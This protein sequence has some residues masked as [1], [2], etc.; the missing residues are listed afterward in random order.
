VVSQHDAVSGWELRA[1]D[2]SLAFLLTVDGVRHEVSWSPSFEIAE[3]W[4]HLAGTFDGDRLELRINGVAVPGVGQNVSGVITPSAGPLRIGQSAY[5]PGRIFT[6]QLAEVRVWE[7]A[8]NFGELNAGLFRRLAGDEAGLLAYWPLAEGTGDSLADQSMG[9]RHGTGESMGWVAADL[10]PR[11]PAGEVVE[12][13]LA[14]R[15]RQLAARIKEKKAELKRAVGRRR[16]REDRKELRQEQLAGGEA[17]WEHER[18]RLDDTFDNQIRARE[19]Q[20]EAI[21]AAQ[22]TEDLN[23]VDALLGDIVEKTH[24]Q[25]ERA[26]DTLDRGDSP[27]RLGR[28]CLDLRYVAGGGGGGATLP[29][30]ETIVEGER[31]T[32]LHLDFA[33]DS[34]PQPPVLAPVNKVP[35]VVGYTSAVARRKVA[36]AGFLVE[37]HSRAVTADDQVGRVVEQLPRAEAEV[38]PESTVGLFIGKAS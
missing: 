2:H 11:L 18:Q 17:A 28:V 36:A 4:M 25:I 26:R 34:P 37:L 7:S 1:T 30:A 3:R 5:R 20:I 22:R 12:T 27:Y 29:E 32:S 21:Y 8:R 35:G 23:E 16:Y 14:Y 33:P 15:V 10:P 19:L 6:G 13:D 9:G 31:V 24:E 38:A